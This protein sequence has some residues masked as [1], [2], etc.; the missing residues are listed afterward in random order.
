L[1]TEELP[2]DPHK[3]AIFFGPL[4]LGGA[5]GTSG[6]PKSQEARD[7]SMF[8]KVGDVEVPALAT[9]HKPIERWLEPVAGQ[10]LAFRT[11]GVGRP[12]DVT[13][14]PFYRQYHERST[15]YWEVLD[16]P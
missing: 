1:S 7:Q 2:D 12:H 4:V 5:L 13:L 8:R 10:S 9:G 11:K 16:T 14:V 15:V 3:I 6:L